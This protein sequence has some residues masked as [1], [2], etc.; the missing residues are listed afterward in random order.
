[1]LHVIAHIQIFHPRFQHRLDALHDVI[2]L[3]LHVDQ[4]RVMTGTGIGTKG[5]V[6]IGIPADA[7]TLVGLGSTRP[8]IIKRAVI[9]ARDGERRAGLGYFKPGGKDD[10]VH[11]VFNTFDRADT[12]CGKVGNRPGYEFAVVFL[13]A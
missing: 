13:Q 1:M 9:Q 2:N 10:A 11:L 7:D 12:V 8:L 5:H 4:R 6:Q 3:R